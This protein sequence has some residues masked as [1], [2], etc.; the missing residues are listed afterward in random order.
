MSWAIARKTETQEMM[1]QSGDDE[2]T[3]RDRHQCVGIERFELDVGPD[4]EDHEGR[5]QQRE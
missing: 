5:D 4:R 2:E 3:D 1:W